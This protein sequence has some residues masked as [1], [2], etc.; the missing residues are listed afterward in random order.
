M[1]NHLRKLLDLIFS[2]I[3]ALQIFKS[4]A[5]SVPCDPYHPALEI[6]FPLNSE[7]P[8]IDVSH[9]YYNF[10]KANCPYILNYLKS[11]NWAE[12]INLID[13]DSATYT[14]YDALH[15]YILNFVPIIIS[16]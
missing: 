8:T 10:H 15:Y 4:T 14:L 2:N 12:T 1:P 3:N 11:F 16:M 5:V 13:I 7:S 9:T 6:V